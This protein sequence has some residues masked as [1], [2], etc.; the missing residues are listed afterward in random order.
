MVQVEVV[1][2]SADFRNYRFIGLKNGLRV[3]LISSLKPGES[4]EYET[5]SGSD[6]LEDC[7]E[8]EAICH[9][10]ET[11]KV[12]M[13]KSAAALCVNVGYFTD[14]MEA[15]G[16]AHFLEHM[17]FMGSEK[18]PREN[19][20][21]DYVEHR[22]GGSNACTDGDYTMFFFDIQR[23]N[24]EEALD[25]FANFFI[26]P[27]LSQDCI[28]RELEAVH[29]EFELCKAD[30][31]CRFD[32]LLTSFSKEGSPY[33]IFGVGNR[34]SLRDKPSAAGTNVYELLRKF[35][36][37]YYNASLMTL[38][39]ES[40]DTLD[41][42]ESM[43]NE[44]FGAIPNRSCEAPDLS[45]FVEP[46]PPT[47]YKKVYKVCPVKETVSISFTWSLAPMHSHYRSA[48]LKLV[49]SIVG[50]E[51]KGSLVAYLR[52]LNLAVELSAGCIINDSV[53]HNQMTSLF[54]INIELSELGRTAPLTVAGHVF[55]YLRMLRDAADFSLA[56]PSATTTPWGDRTFA[57]LVPEFE[58]L[59]VS[60]FR[61]QEPLEPSTNVQTIAT[62][63]RK[64]PPHEVFIAESLILEPDLK[65][66]VDVVRHL[67]PE[68]AI[69]AVTLPELNAHSMADTKEEVFHREPWFDIR[70]AIDEISDDQ[71]RRW[72]NSPALA[73]FHLPEVNRFIATDFG[74]LPQGD[75]NEPFGELWHQQR[76]KF[77]VPTAHVIVHIYSDLPQQAKDAAILRLWSCALNQRLHTL[78][79]CAN[80]AGLSYSVSALDRGLEIAVA[81]F[82]EKLFLLY[83]EIIGVLAQPLA[84]SNKEC[85]LH[86]GNFAVYKDRLRQKT[87]NRLLDP[88][89]LNTHLR[90]YLRQ[91]NIHL[92]EDCMKAL[93]GLT[94]N[95]ML[96][97]VPAFFSRLYVKGFV[98][99]NVSAAEAKEYVDYALST[100][101]PREVAVVKP[102]PKAALPACLNRL[103]VMNF[104]K[105]DVNTYLVLMSFLQGTPSDDLRY[106]VMNELLESCLQESAYSYLRTRETLG[107][108]VGLYTWSLA[109]TTG[110]CGLSVSVSSQANK[111]DSNLVAGRM[112]AFWYRIVPYIVLHLNEEAFQT[113][114]EAL[115][116][117]NLLEDAT[118][119]IEISRNLKEVFSGR[120]IFDRRQRAVEILRQL[121]LS[122]LQDFYIKTYYD[123]E[124][125]PTLM[126]QVDSLSD[127]ESMDASSK[128][129]NLNCLK[130]FD[131]PLSVVPM[132]G[133]QVEAERNATLA[134][135]VHE[136]VLACASG[137]V[138]DAAKVDLNADFNVEREKAKVVLPRI[139]EIL[140]VHD[141][142]HNVLFPSSP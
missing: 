59:W 56:N 24:F 133:D 105:T 97:F 124:R 65:T 85:L 32:H 8:E 55:S 138:T 72:Q 121:K 6:V 136:A 103:R 73:D 4:A 107:Y 23:V 109:S 139:M 95:D 122:D 26:A 134:V 29:S 5:D 86:D 14:P 45:A 92:V 39:V 49:A 53:H 116:S 67:T 137:L 142:K 22:G 17:V 82:N 108:S 80:E 33:R 127:A 117:T 41:H 112:Y 43:V 46:F 7:E 110:Q 93:E 123:L 115:I 69:I 40:K 35:Q 44:I 60:T 128:G 13:R 99:G 90:K 10:D 18:Y 104:N 101:K 94:V 11:S 91:A 63:M 75:D 125:Q 76:V 79:H 61:F 50:Y 100:L 31:S 74:L 30:D 15:Q 118:M 83:Q 111:F 54:G 102:Y 16:L 129:D 88:R 84:G 51:G 52:K 140:K 37:R 9:D 81:G 114:V 132:S 1:K 21:D 36:L 120:P 98:Y 2:S 66:Y 131:W 47:V 42:L 48:A 38:A 25:K 130:T 126:I 70:Y 57:S 62:A 3:M 106:E 12:A 34:I 78:L 87:C 68:K 77:N 89:K 27:L 135:D 20:F 19:D 113:S 28:D 119:D 58:K 64:F 71:I 141:F 96:L